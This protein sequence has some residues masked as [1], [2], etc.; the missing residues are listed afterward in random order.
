MRTSTTTRRRAVGIV[1]VS[2]T[3]GRAGE[4]FTSPRTQRERIEADC[5]REG[6]VLVEC[7]EELD[8]SGGRSL[9]ARPHL[10]EAVRMIEDGEADVIV[11]AYFDRLVRSLTTQAELLERVHAAGGQVRAVDAGAISAGTSGEWLDATMRGMMAEYQRRQGAERTHDAQADAIARGVAMWPQIPVGYRKGAD[12]H[13]EVDPVTAP[14]VAEAYALRA[15]GATVAVVRT[16]LAGAGLTLSYTAVNNLLHTRAVLGELHFGRYE[17]NL[18][19]WPAIVDR[20]T[21]DRVQRHVAPRGRQSSS[22]RLLARLGV[23]RCASCGSSMVVSV[24]TQQGKP[25]YYYRCGAKTDCTARPAISATM[26][27]EHV[28]T[29][30]RNALGNVRGRA[31]A[32]S[33]LRAAEVEAEQTQADLDAAIRMLAAVGDEPAAIERLGEL[34]AARDA[35]RSRVEQLGIGQHGV[36]LVLDADWDWDVLSVAERRAMIRGTV[37][38]VTV[39]TGRGLERVTVRLVGEQQGAERVLGGAARRLISEGVTG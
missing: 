12:R 31:S 39:A 25:Y 24:Q 11:A 28:T 34:Q 7:F 6:L 36:A 18:A 5:E 9:A 4:A 16:Y 3:G 37:E 27:E 29:A 10:S 33:G 17:P 32:E 14:L 8:T 21:W 30:V 22:E 13:L 2:V 35:T 20:D 19:A 15:D 26:I 23:L 38:S 1:R